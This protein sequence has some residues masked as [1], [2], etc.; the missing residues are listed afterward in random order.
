[1]VLLELGQVWWH[2]RGE[3]TPNLYIVDMIFTKSMYRC[4]IEK[5][6][7]IVSREQHF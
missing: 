6:A 1:M 5:V 3:D 4:R 7:S 2:I